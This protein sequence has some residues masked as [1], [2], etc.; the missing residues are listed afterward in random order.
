MNSSNNKPETLKIK[1]AAHNKP[2][3]TAKL[4]SFKTL[5]KKKAISLMPVAA[6]VKILFIFHNLDLL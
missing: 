4:D 1:K 3:P 2:K 6:V 5:L